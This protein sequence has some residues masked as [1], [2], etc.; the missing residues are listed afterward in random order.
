MFTDS[1]VTPRRLEV[2]I[3]VLREYSRRDW[4]RE[5]LYHTLQPEGLSG[6]VSNR[7][8]ARA[9]I[10]AAS[11]LGL[12]EE[13]AGVIELAPR[14]EAKRPVRHTVLDALDRE[15]LA[16]TDVEPWFGLFYAFQLGLGAEGAKPCTADNWAKRFLAEA[17]H[18]VP[19]PNPFNG[20]KH[21]GLMRWFPYA[22]LGWI[23]GRRTFQANPYER[24]RR[25]LPHVFGT[26]KRLNGDDFMVG[27][28][29][30]CPELDGGNLFRQVNGSW[31]V[32]G[33]V[34]TLGLSHALVDLHLAG[35]LRLVGTVD[36]R[37]WSVQ[38]ANPPRTDFAGRIDFVELPGGDN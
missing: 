5:T 19:Y 21:S 17:L 27:L 6:G 29:N 4:K 2:L 15:V 7:D 38:L 30:A 14:A 33:K 12:V 8:P 22:G 35:H 23:D 3:S 1:Y 34:C 28:A 32:R 18:S 24:L 31:D 11:E 20:T 37:G 13:K 10:A 25:A 36:S 26:S 9:T 16:K